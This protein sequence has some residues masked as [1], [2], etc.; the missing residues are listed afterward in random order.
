M[1][2]T[3]A[4][5]SSHSPYIELSREQWRA[6]ASSTPLPLT[7]DDVVKLRGLGDPT[8]LTEVDAVYRP[9]TA[10]LQDYILTSRERARRIAEL[11]GVDARPTPFVIAVAGSVAVGKSTA[12]RLI[13]H[14]LARFPGTPRV[15]LVTTDGFLLSNAELEARGLMSRKGFPESYDRRALVDFVA[16]VKSGA[17]RVEA[18]VYSHQVYDIVPGR[19]VV[20]ERP[21]VLVLEGLNVLQP[22]P[23]GRAAAEHPDEP[24]G[25]PM[26]SVLAVSDFIDFSI[27]VDADPADIRRWYLERFLT[28][29]RTA[30]NDPDSY[31]Q[32]FASIPD[33]IALTAA[34]GIWETVNLVNLRENIAPT[35][36]RATLVLVKGSDHHMRRVLL[37]KS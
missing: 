3:W 2:Q 8:D 37:R 17:P 32:R 21:D 12:A 30:F 14:L 1:R 23:R 10:I 34:S 26:G 35:R 15:D 25:H 7:Q 19:S 28:L 6:L 13:A 31:F 20:V 36:G 18:P 16:A 4:V 24:G 33:D 27:Y 5:T 9:L 11:L 22:A 29:K